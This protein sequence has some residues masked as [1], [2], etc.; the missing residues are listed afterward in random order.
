MSRRRKIVIGVVAGCLVVAGVAA[1]SL[2]G[3]GTSSSAPVIVVA[4]VAPRTLQ[5]TVQLNGTLARKSIRNVT[6][7]S[8]G[9]VTSVRASDGDRVRNGDVLF[10]LNGRQAVAEPGSLPFYRSL[11]PGDSGPDVVQLKAILAASGDYPGPPNGLFTQQTQFALAQWQ[12]QHHY[13]NATPASPEAVAVS[14]Q[15]G[16]GYQLGT[17][18][19][20]GLTIGPPTLAQATAAV[21]PGRGASATLVAYRRVLPAAAP[22]LTIQSV[23]AQVSEGQ[24]ATFVITASAATSSDVT[25]NL[26]TGGSATSQDI[27]TPPSSVVLPA[28]YTST[29]VVVQTRS[30][31]TVAAD[32]TVSISLAPGTGYVVGT[33]SSAQTTIANANVPQLTITGGTTVAPGGSATLTVTAN[34]A[35]LAATQVFLSFAGDAT[36]G[37]DY[38]PP[39]PVVTL[40]A[41][42]TSATVT[43]DTLNNQVIQADKFIVV[44]LTPQPGSYTVGSP[45]AAV[46]TIGGSG[47]LPTL[48][49]TS[50]LSYLE[51]GQPYMV[52]VGLSEALSRPLTVDLSY[53]GSAVEGVDYIPP[54][55]T[56]VVPPDQTA[57]SV[58]IPTVTDDRVEADRVLDVSLAPSAGYQI[59]SPSSTSV[60]ISSQVLPKLSLTASTSAVSQGGAASFT[61]TADQ[62]PVKPTSV[63]FVVQGTAQPGQNYV[64]LTGVALLAPG[65]TSVTVVLQSIQS[66]ITFEP[67][68]MIVGH[69][70]I[71]VGTVYVKAGSTIAP[72]EPILELTEPN[73][74]VTLQASAS[75]R[76]NL[77]VGQACTV[78]ISGGTTQVNGTITELDA[79]PT[80]VSAGVPGGGS[81]QVY[82]GRVDSPDLYQLHGTDG[83][84]VSITVV[85][86]QVSNALTVPI[87]AVKQNGLGADV[88]RVIR[89]SGVVVETRVTTGLSEGS[90]IQVKNGVRLGQTVVVQSV[91]S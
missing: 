52:D 14:L 80:N 29:T 76:S 79:T 37:T 27:V 8:E 36:P 5:S 32:R 61:I 31:T 41:G 21:R 59:G 4:R 83:A 69:W 63:N 48:T 38:T 85:D 86:Q 6:A 2:S 18:I 64:P 13:P 55:G 1:W 35:P 62:A 53:G 91:N 71:R 40:A 50:P 45:G 23:S 47:A 51:K 26:S 9:L 65:Q 82:E 60:T 49:L 57:F 43:V 28:G 42:A 24:P 33:P 54:P 10:S 81:S 74:S 34:V 17:Q 70:P 78:Q 25:V 73:L 89:P 15:Q 75:D 11:V 67:T 58:T 44:T 56:I 16:S 88:V 46:V 77:R 66:N 39:N 30:T 20:A 84:S 22:T 12:A 19:S 90:Y 87:A 7:A 3:G 68:D 72:G